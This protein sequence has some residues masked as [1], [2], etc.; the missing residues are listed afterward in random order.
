MLQVLG[1]VSRSVPGGV[2][3]VRPKQRNKAAAQSK[4]VDAPISRKKQRQ[5]QQTITKPADAV[6]AAEANAADTLL[7]PDGV[8]ADAT[9]DATLV[10]RA[11]ERGLKLDASTLD[12][13]CV[14]YGLDAR[15]SCKLI[16]GDGPALSVLLTT[17]RG[18]YQLRA[19]GR[20]AVGRLGLDVEIAIIAYLRQRAFPA[21]DLL[22]TAAGAR[23]V[24]HDGVFYAVAPAVAGR[25]YES[26]AQAIAAGRILAR[27]HTFMRSFEGPYRLGGSRYLPDVIGENATWLRGMQRF[28]SDVRPDQLGELEPVFSDA[29]RRLLGLQQ[30]IRDLYDNEPRL[31]T[32]GSFT[33]DAVLFDHGVVVKVDAFEQTSYDIRLTDVAHACIS[34]CSRT[35]ETDEAGHAPLERGRYRQFLAGYGEAAPLSERESRC[36]PLLIQANHITSF[37]AQCRASFDA[38]SPEDA[39]E[40]V[41]NIIES[42]E[43][44]R[45]QMAVDADCMNDD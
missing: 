41:R 5:Q 18:D 40:L 27:F 12:R 44:L 20:D 9:S 24:R 7:L 38:S 33:R 8:W 15:L 36:L 31:V 43:R 2:N 30:P 14:A 21:P 4:T 45:G 28:V 19:V 37:V 1:P 29:S 16:E 35:G 32:H 3:G 17:T 13:L 6:N 34:F 42:A 39:G 11:A 22:T 26:D 10:E 23:Y 25:T